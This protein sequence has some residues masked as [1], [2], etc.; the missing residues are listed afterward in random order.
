VHDVCDGADAVLRMH[1]RV[2]LV[3]VDAAV[4]RGVD[5]AG[6]YRVDADTLARVFHCKRFG[7]GRE[8]TL[9]QCRQRGWDCGLRLF[10]QRGGDVDDVASTALVKNLA[11]DALGDVKEPERVHRCDQRIVLGRIRGEGLR[12]EHAG[13]VDEGV[14][15]TKRSSSN[16]DQPPCRRRIADIACDSEYSGIV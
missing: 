2:G 14:D 8:A 9:G 6:R 4:H 13:I 11:D 3:R 5:D 15:A 16:V 1:P 7:D 12:D 10:G